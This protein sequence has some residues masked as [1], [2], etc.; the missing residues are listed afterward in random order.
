[1]RDVADH[2]AHGRHPALLDQQKL[3]FDVFHQLLR[4]PLFQGL[5]EV[6]EFFHGPFALDNFPN[7]LHQQ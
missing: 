2:L 7:R 3:V 4:H 5:V 1:M 6:K